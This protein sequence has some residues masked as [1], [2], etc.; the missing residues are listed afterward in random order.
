MQDTHTRN[1]PK[2]IEHL[3][4]PPLRPDAVVQ[5]RLVLG[6]NRADGSPLERDPRQ[7]VVRA[8]LPLRLE[9]AGRHMRDFERLPRLR[10]TPLRDVPK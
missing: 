9:L 2:H 4:R 10:L 8:R 5:V 1:L 3:L 7:E 6:H